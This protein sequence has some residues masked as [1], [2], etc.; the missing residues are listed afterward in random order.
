MA[1]TGLMNP[2]ALAE[3]IVKQIGDTDHNSAV[4]ALEIARLLLDHR[5]RAAIRFNAAAVADL[6]GNSHS[7]P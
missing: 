2:T 6:A 1:V 7:I 5:E 4:T 3:Q